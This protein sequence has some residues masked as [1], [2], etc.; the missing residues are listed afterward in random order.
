MPF[1]FLPP[2]M[3]PLC[4][5]YDQ[6]DCVRQTIPV[7]EFLIHVLSPGASQ[8]VELGFAA[9]LISPPIGLEPALLFE[10]VE[11]RI[12]RA[13]LNLQCFFGDL[14]NAF[15]DGPPVLGLER[16]CFEDQKIQHAM[17]KIGWLR[18]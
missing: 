9:G 13:L 17:D 10:P 7:F 6:I 11:R 12:E 1:V 4:R 16:D 18:H 14:L 8:R 5:P 2:F 15:G 3:D